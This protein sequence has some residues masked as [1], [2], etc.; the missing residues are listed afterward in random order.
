MTR[1]HCGWKVGLICGSVVSSIILFAG[2]AGYLGGAPVEYIVAIPPLLMAS[3]RGLGDVGFAIL[4]TVWWG[5]I[6]TLLGWL[7]GKGRWGGPLTVATIAGLAVGHYY[8]LKQMKSDLGQVG[9]VMGELL[10]GLF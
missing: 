10:L 7:A 5:T 6:G 2:A 4:F 8:A 1:K 3:V 9:N